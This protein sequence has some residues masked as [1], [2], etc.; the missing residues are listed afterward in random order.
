MLKRVVKSILAELTLNGISRASHSVSVRAAALDHKAVNDSV[1]NQSVIKTFFYQ[2]YKI[3]Y[4]VR[5]N[6][7]IELGLH[8]IAIF[9]GYCNNRIIHIIITSFLC[10]MHSVQPESILPNLS[11]LFKTEDGISI[12]FGAVQAV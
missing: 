7:R 11:R 12:L 3:I 2:T 9:H 4:C 5:S 1:E 10:T 8:D 6:L